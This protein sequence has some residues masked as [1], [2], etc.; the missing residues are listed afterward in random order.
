MNTIQG[1]VHSF[2]MPDRYKPITGLADCVLWRM[3]SINCQV[4]NSCSMPMSS[5]H[6]VDELDIDE[7]GV[8]T[9]KL[10]KVSLINDP[11][12]SKLFTGVGHMPI[13]PVK[14]KLKSNA[15]S[16]QTPF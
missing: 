3:V 8:K 12:F 14:I 16:C 2:F 15:V 10:M 7:T 13:K 4:T 1:Y 5:D 11:K 9:S 6:E